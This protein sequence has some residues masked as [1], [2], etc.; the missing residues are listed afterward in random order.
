MPSTC[1]RPR[2][3]TLVELLVVIA[4][5]GILIALLLPAV[6]A[7]REAARRMTCTSHLRQIALAMHLYNDAMQRLPPAQQGGLTSAFVAIMPF[8]EQG[9]ARELYNIKK[10]YHH[11]DNQRVVNQRIPIYLCPSMYLPREVPSV[12]PPHNEVGAPGSYAVNTG[13][14]F[15]LFT[16]THNGAIIHPNS[17]YTSIGLITQLDGV[18]NTLLL[19][20]MNYAFDN[21]YWQLDE[22]SSGIKWGENR[23]ASGYWCVTWGSSY[24]VFNAKRLI[25][26]AAAEELQ[27]FRSDHPGGAN[28]AFADGSVRFIPEFVNK[29]TLDGLATRAGKEAVNVEN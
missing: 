11:P 26:P 5:I 19:G 18:S 23:W 25:S 3:F 29:T 10:S 6:Q 27:S 4:I 28:F 1:R 21:Y 24:G 8:L 13:S 22:P 12:E 17:G 7:A 16:T 15:S 20:E 2:A 14:E 9:A